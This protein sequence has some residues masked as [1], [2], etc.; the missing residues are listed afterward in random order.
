MKQERAGKLVRDG[1]P[2]LIEARGGSADVSVLDADE[3]V[4][5]LHEK[6][7]EEAAELEAAPPDSQLEELA[8]VYEV[9][10][11]LVTLL[12]FSMVQVQDAADKKRAERGGFD[13][14]LWLRSRR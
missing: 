10:T 13:E 11:A 3:Y 9:M 4:A 7:R 2:A 6:L 1:I 5:A 8:D 14:R 12:G